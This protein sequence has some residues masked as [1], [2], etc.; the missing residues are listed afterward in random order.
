MLLHVDG[1]KFAIKPTGGEIGGI[2]A[3]FTKSS[4]VKDLTVKQ[5]A[6]ALTAGK[7]IEPGVCPFSEKSH[8]AG[9]TGTCKDDFAKQ[10]IF[11]SDIDNENTDAPQETPA[12]IA[13]L[14]H[15]NGL[16]AAFMYESY[17]SR[18]ENLRFRFAVVCS[19]E[20]TDDREREKIQGA[21]IAMSPQSDVGCINADRIFFGTDK[22]LLEAYTDFEAVCS[23]ESLLA[24]ADKYRMPEMPKQADTKKSP[25]TKYGET[26]PTGQRHGT[27]VSF[28][29]AV[30]KK[31]GIS[32]QAHEAYMKRVAQCE[33]PKPDSE[34][35]KIWRDACN[36]Y[37]RRIAAD[38]GYRPPD[39]YAVQEFESSLEPYDYTDVGQ[40]RV[41]VNQYGGRI[42]YSTA[43]KWLVYNGMKWNE[44]E[45][46]VQGLVQQLTD[47]QLKEARKM[48]H[49]ANAAEETAAESE[50]SEQTEAV[51]EALRAAKAY[52]KF[53]L[54]YR[55][56]NRISAT[57]T[58][59]RPAV[60]IDVTELDKDPFLLNTPV[61]T[62]DL[63]TGR[64]K[65][66]DPGDFI[67]KI[68]AVSPSMDGMDEWFAFLDRLTCSDRELQNYLQVSSGE[69]IVGQV[70]VEN[71]QIAY[72]NGG[73]GKSSYYNA[74]F[75]CLGDYAGRISAEILT[76]NCRN[77]KKPEL[78]DLRGKRL[79]IA[80]ELDE[81]T[82]LD[83]GAVKQICSVDPIRGE[84]KFKDGFDFV[85]SHTTILYT[86][87]L[88]KVGA[89][90]SGTW[91]RLVVVPFRANFRGMKDEIMNY[92]DY[93][94]KHCGG[95]ILL[96]M[97]QGAQKYIAAQYHIEKPESVK[98][99][100]AEYRFDN[101]WINE[102]V[103]ECCE[104]SPE[105]EQ[106]AG[107]LYD[108][109]RT[110]C[111][112][113]H[114]WARGAGDFKAALTNAGYLWRKTKAGAF[115]SGIRLKSEFEPIVPL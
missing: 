19:E 3:R 113:T 13:A 50:D 110:E 85:P 27:L 46:E 97:I 15:E 6:A 1:R 84:K 66:H 73:N 55:K 32:E 41:F 34:I 61:G 44:S 86:N 60:L 78:A 40:A 52:R 36:Y 89:N 28:A 92:A 108:A 102:F 95:A 115:Y 59:A 101:D 105:Y 99:A 81:G 9:K 29:S 31:Y 7:T 11:L 74:E 35:E 18:P 21:L 49:A 87:H 26:I 47:R 63:R 22:G 10:T 93:L 68:T 82:R 62:V 107:N 106:K 111:G 88:P 48:L 51:K 57:M 75:M 76:A 53:V 69:T 90:D 12:H 45:L 71:L 37:E 91:D 30:L 33:D 2:K 98:Q 96:W 94:F 79:I 70:F 72:G 38:P 23:K 109:Y 100:I 39:E 42:R 58:E 67:T 8:K 20:I 17:H 83:T 104:V 77:N 16:K 64:I 80:A 114:E 56:T 112:K 54:D 103:T 5:I 24:L 4:S 25:W 65:P 43:T 14:L